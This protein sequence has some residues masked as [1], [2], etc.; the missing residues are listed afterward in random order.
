[1]IIDIAEKLLKV[2]LK[3]RQN[4]PLDLLKFFLFFGGGV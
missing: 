1:M 3:E 4:S 2:A